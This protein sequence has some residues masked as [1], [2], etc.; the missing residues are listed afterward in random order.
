[1]RTTAVTGSASGIGAALT[2]QLR[3]AGERVI[4]IDLMDADVCADLGS[5]AG[6]SQALQQLRAFSGGC[7]DALVTCAGVSSAVH[8]E[9]RVLAVN[10]FGT[11]ELLRELRADLARGTRPAAV[12]ISSW[13]LLQATPRPEAIA[14]CLA[15]DEALALQLV[16]ADPRVGEIWP[17]YATAKNALARLVRAWAPSP[18]W[19]GSGITLNALVP[20]AT[21]TPMI[22][23]HLATPEGTQALL[24]ATPSPTGRIA[25]AEDIAEP[26]AF[27]A[28]GR[29]RHLSGQVIF[30]DGGLEARRR[31][32]D[33]LE[34]LPPE[35]WR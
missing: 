18:E 14:A 22:A 2:R 12:V 13:A 26:A 24:A 21:R 8:D 20:A 35:R 17:A 23:R 7:L 29:A 34:P 33:A 16:T 27:L 10:Y 25:E 11:A 6:R 5:P 30:V 31:P 15:F 19:A 28:S 9:A 3:A 1:M 32:F 4:G